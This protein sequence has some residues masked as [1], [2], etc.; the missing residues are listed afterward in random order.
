MLGRGEAFHFIQTPLGLG[1][2]GGG[3]KRG[4][5]A[6]GR[7]GWESVKSHCDYECNCS[8][9]AQGPCSCDGARGCFMHGNEEEESEKERKRESGRE[10][11]DA[12]MFAVSLF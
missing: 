12:K 11:Q 1:C 7:G 5:M 6:A 8:S 10:R 4:G 9:G 2:R 3:K